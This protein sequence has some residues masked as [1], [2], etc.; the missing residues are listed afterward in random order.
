MAIFTPDN[1]PYLGR[2]SVHQFDNLLTLFIEEQTR[3]GTWTRSAATELTPL[4]R[5]ASELVPP[6]SSIVLSIRELVRQGYL[7]SALIL[8]RPL[9][10]RVATLSYLIENPSKVV[11]WEQGWPHK[12]RPPLAERIRAMTDVKESDP[13]LSTPP[14][15][16][17]VAEILDRYNGLVHGDPSGALHGAILLPDGRPGFTIGKDL[18]SPARADEVCFETVSWLVV[19]L[20]RCSQLFPPPA[21]SAADG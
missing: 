20:A 7:L 3:I 8:T 5:A 18:N 1:E 13:S 21:H 19:L 10:E 12:S 16:T 6:A 9:M 2:T 17:E 4:Q 15:E 11:L 14:T